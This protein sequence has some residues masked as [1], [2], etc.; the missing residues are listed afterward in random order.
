MT[1]HIPVEL[2]LKTE[3][4]QEN[5]KIW[6]DTSSTGFEFITSHKP[7]ILTVDPDFD[8]PSV[9]W[10]PS[11]LG[12]L[13]NSYPEF[14]VIYGTQ[15]EA[16]ANK[17]A[18]ERFMDEFAGLDHK[19]I[20]ADTV[21]TE[22]D[23]QQSLILFGRPETNKIS[24]RFSDSFPLK[25]KKDRFYWQDTVYDSP[26]QGVALIIE[27][28]LD[29]RHSVNLY[30]GLS[31]DATLKVCNTSEWQEE[32]DGWLLIDYKSS[33]VIYD[34][35]KRLV[36]GDWEDTSSNLVWFFSGAISEY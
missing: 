23:L 31:G 14:M 26:N 24:R 25:F 19:L 8:I 11:H 17:K 1:F 28:P 22:N 29:R 27:N 18:A 12:M 21:V 5:Q 16:E 6:L 15:A 32:L 35:H 13:W 3:N 34:N 20:K 33:Y 30:A 10:M 2:A 36:S 4:G 7:E 9:R